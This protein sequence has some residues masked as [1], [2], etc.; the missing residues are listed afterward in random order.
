MGNS[1]ETKGG[2]WNGGL[3]GV[4]CRPGSEAMVGGWG[5]SEVIGGGQ[6]YLQIC[7]RCQILCLPG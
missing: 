4:G 7:G 6:V 3:G 2:E 1:R 5:T